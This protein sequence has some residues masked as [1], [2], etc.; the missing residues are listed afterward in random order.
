MNL[1]LTPEQAHLIQQELETGNYAD[2]NDLLSTALNLLTQRRHY[3][4]WA[5]EV[6]EKVDVAAA[7]L[8]GGDGID[9]E[10]AIAYLKARLHQA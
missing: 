9:G 1:T 6:Q 4:Q 2:I 3:D 10:T 7:E 8:E 5:K